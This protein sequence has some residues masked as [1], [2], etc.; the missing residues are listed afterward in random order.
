MLCFC[1]RTV[2]TLGYFE[3][4]SPCKITAHHDDVAIIH[5]AGE[6]RILTC[7]SIRVQYR[8]GAF[9]Q[10]HIISVVIGGFV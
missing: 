6:Y 8:R 7:T 2:R 3:I 9:L 1:T 5:P 10:L 4:A